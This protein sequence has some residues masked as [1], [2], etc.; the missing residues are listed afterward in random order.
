MRHFQ[1]LF[2]K[3]KTW[4][5]IFGWFSWIYFFFTSSCMMWSLNCF[6]QSAEQFYD[7]TMQE[8]VKTGKF[9][10]I[11][12]QSDVK[13]WVNW[14][15]CGAVSYLSSCT[16]FLKFQKP[17]C[18]SGR[19]RTGQGLSANIKRRPGRCH[20]NRPIY[21]GFKFFLK[22]QCQFSTHALQRNKNLGKGQKISE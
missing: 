2:N 5:G 17:N 20:P 12:Q 22:K 1:I 3:P 21:N 19:V 16:R 7:H 11:N 13:F 14:I 6:V 9:S 10:Y 8:L 15:K 4:N 18:W